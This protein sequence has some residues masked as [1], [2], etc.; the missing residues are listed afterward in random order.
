MTNESRQLLIDLVSRKGQTPD[1]VGALAAEILPDLG[2]EGR[3]L[4]TGD[5]VA[6]IN[7]GNVTQATRDDVGQACV[8]N[9]WGH[10][11]AKELS[12]A[13]FSIAVGEILL[14]ADSVRAGND[15]LLPRLLHQTMGILSQNPFRCDIA[16]TV[17]I[18]HCV[19]PKTQD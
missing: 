6:M 7:G 1:P 18:L 14:A 2:H 4:T 5:L 15:V 11:A 12:E 13:E 16:E 19:L 10:M 9:L 8:E 3:R 17:H